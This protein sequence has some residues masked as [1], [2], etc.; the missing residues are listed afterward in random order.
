MTSENWMWWAGRDDERY[1]VGPCETK[2]QAI[3]G[4]REDFDGDSFCII[5]A[6]Q[7]DDI[8]LADTLD[9]DYLLEIAEEKAYDEYADPEGDSLIFDLST[10]QVKSF[11]AAIKEAIEAWQN[12]EGLTFKSFLFSKTRNFEVIAGQDDA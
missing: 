2:E 1:T 6:I 8:R 12:A 9:G 11:G 7:N 3:E 5:E 4:G 10:D